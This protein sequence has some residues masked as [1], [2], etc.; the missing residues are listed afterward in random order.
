MHSRFLSSLSRILFVG[1]AVGLG[2]SS[3]YG[4]SSSSTPAAPQE[5]PI[6]RID[7][8]AGYS[9]LAPKATVNTTLDNGSTFSAT[10]DAIDYGA[11]LSGAY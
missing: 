7:V 1:C 5:Q 8:F 9:Y 4:Q 3:M 10:Y 11:I 6:S 2:A